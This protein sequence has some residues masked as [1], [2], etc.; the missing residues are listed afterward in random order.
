VIFVQFLAKKRR[1]ISDKDF[2]IALF[3]SVTDPREVTLWTGHM[4]NTFCHLAGGVDAAEG[5]S[6][7]PIALFHIAL[8]RG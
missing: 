7:Y 3:P 2:Q 6:G 5:V 8:Q 1:E 4:S